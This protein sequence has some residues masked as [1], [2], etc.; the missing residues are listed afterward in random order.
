MLALRTC[1]NVAISVYG[2]REAIAII[3]RYS[4]EELLRRNGDHGP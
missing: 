3:K 1:G 2:V 4:D